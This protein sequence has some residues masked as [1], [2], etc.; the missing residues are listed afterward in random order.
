[1]THFR[2]CGAGIRGDAGH[3]CNVGLENWFQTQVAADRGCRSLPYVV[4]EWII[5]PQIREFPGFTA[6]SA[7]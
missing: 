4:S 5:P 6:R 2:L 7:I 3:E 1:M